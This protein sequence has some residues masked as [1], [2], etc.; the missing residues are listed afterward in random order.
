MAPALHTHTQK[1]NNTACSCAIVR[2]NEIYVWLQTIVIGCSAM[3]QIWSDSDLKHRLSFQDVGYILLPKC[4]AASMSDNAIS[5]TLRK[6][7]V[8]LCQTKS[9][10]L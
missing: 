4:T 2:H 9:Q 5:M 3:Q 1:K 10:I 8:I 6:S 7:Q